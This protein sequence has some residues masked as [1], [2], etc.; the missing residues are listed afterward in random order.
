MF[1]FFVAGTCTS[2]VDA[3]KVVSLTPIFDTITCLWRIICGGTKSV[4]IVGGRS[5]N[6]WEKIKLVKILAVSIK[7]SGKFLFGFMEENRK[8][9]TKILTLKY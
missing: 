5:K 2:G 7:Q 6:I 8:D 3:I 1:L 4:S 9:M